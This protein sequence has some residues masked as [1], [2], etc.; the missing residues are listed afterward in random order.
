MAKYENSEIEL[1]LGLC[2]YK[3]IENLSR[4]NTS[5]L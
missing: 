4:V 5:S 1:T 2:R 3:N